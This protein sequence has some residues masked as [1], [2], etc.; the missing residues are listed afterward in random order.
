MKR[1]L[2]L[3]DWL[4]RLFFGVYID[5]IK[6]LESQLEVCRTQLS[7]V[8]K[9]LETCE[10]TKEAYFSKL[11]ECMNQNKQLQQRIDD[12]ELKNKELYEK[13]STCQGKLER[14]VNPNPQDVPAILKEILTHQNIQSLTDTDKARLWFDLA[15]VC[16]ES[17][18]KKIPRYVVGWQMVEEHF[19]EKYPNVRLEIWDS[20]FTLTTEWEVPIKLD[21]V[22]MLDYIPETFDCDNFSSLFSA[23]MHSVWLLS[24]TPEVAGEVRNADTNELLG[25]HAWNFILIPLG[26][27]YPD[28][29]IIKGLT[30]KFY[31][32]QTGDWSEDG[33]FTFGKPVKLVKPVE[34]KPS[35]IPAGVKVKYIPTIEIHYE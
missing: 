31:E 34:G 29:W 10:K 8:Q 3:F 27:F 2:G 13:L 30:H 32:P 24:N 9:N 14:Y 1:W 26:E 33:V 11:E 12:L 19:K 15:E 28:R 7:N 4:K 22:H 20:K 17:F 35:L 6:S 23:R 21:W 5:R 16:K 25:Y 18:V